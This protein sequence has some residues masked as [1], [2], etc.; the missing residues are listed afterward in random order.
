MAYTIDIDTGGTFTDGFFVCDG[1]IKT[2]KVATTPHDLTI[3]FLECIKAGA[4]AFA[5]TAQDLLYNTDIVRFSNTIGTNTII[6]RDGSKVGLIVTRGTEDIFSAKADDGDSPLIH[7][8]MVMGIDEA[9]TTGGIVE[10]V[11]DAGPVLTT[12][13]KLIDQGARCLVVALANAE[14]NPANEGAVRRIIKAE[15]PR[16][17]LGSV[18]VFLASDI[19]TRSGLQQRMNTAVLNAYIHAKL[20]RLLYKASEDLRQHEYRGTLFIDH[21]NGA[22]ARVAKT[23]AV[24]TYNSGPAAGLLGACEVGKTYGL[25]N[26]ISTDMGGTSFDVAYVC[27]GK[28]SYSLQPDIEGFSCNLP[29]LSIRALGMGGGSI[30]AV[31]GGGVKVGPLSAGA[32]PGPAAFDLGGSQPTV[33][34]AN[35][36]LGV[37]DPG[38]FLGGRMPLHLDRASTVIEEVIAGPLGLSVEQAA[39]LIKQQVDKD[40]GMAVSEA[41]S[42]LGNGNDAVIVAYGGA[43]GLHACD[44]A[45]AAG[46]RKI[47]MTPFSAVFSAYSSSLMD[48][49]HIYYRRIDSPFNHSFDPEK[50]ASAIAEMRREAGRDMRGE[51]FR[52]NE[53]DYSL[54]LFIK[55]AGGKR[56]IR[57]DTQI[58]FYQQSGLLEDLIERADAELDTNGHDSSCVLSSVACLVT[59]GISGHPVTELEKAQSHPDDAIKTRRRLFTGEDS[60]EV[61][62]Y[63]RNRL[64]Y[65]HE[66]A[67]PAL[68][69]SDQATLLLSR[70]WKMTI[71]QFNNALLT[72][73]Q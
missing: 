58:D 30:A 72:E 38:F 63:D 11:P 56:E 57:L 18:P 20:A 22:V 28:P 43:G 17:Y 42:H 47:I 40:L 10:Q 6:Q 73:K 67:G 55:D 39:W 36:I 37:L 68:L 65:G 19:S 54:Q 4:E 26:I 34:D 46:I 45:T 33:T 15:Y 44:M 9:I 2:V 60:I 13:Q 29:M 7:A 25:N 12:A 35:L 16:D 41:A 32:L 71:D 52:E 69:E 27:D 53:L 8:N 21:N 64:A 61:P 23:R 5:V 31:D 66:L 24:N 50:L 59:A 49:G 14:I 70:N 51:G 62:V 48:V 1:E 3:C